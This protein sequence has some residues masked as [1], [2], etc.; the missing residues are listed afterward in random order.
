MSTVKAVLIVV[1][2]CAAAWITYP[3]YNSHD[4]KLHTTLEYR[5]GIAKKGTHTNTWHLKIP[6]QFVLH[7]YYVWTNPTYDP[8]KHNSSQAFSIISNLSPDRE[9]VPSRSNQGNESFTVTINNSRLES[10]AKAGENYCIPGSCQPGDVNCTVSINYHGWNSY[11]AVPRNQIANP[12]PA[13]DLA[14]RTL[15]QWTVNIDDLRA[16]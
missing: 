5:N 6:Y 16:P 11:V 7:R 14:I 2:I 8:T 13:C 15:D 10:P 4:L 1:G 3:I 12:Q 9:V